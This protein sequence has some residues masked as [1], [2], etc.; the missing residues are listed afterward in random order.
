MFSSPDVGRGSGCW[1]FS[2]SG[3][4][5]SPLIGHTI[6]TESRAL[7]ACSGRDWGKLLGHSDWRC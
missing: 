7:L 2:L 1:L 3:P 6:W 5:Q 4:F